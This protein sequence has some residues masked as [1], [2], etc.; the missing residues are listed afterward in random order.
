MQF[1]RLEITRNDAQFVL[2]CY[3]SRRKGAEDG[4]H[5]FHADDVE[6]GRAD[7]SMAEGDRIILEGS[8][9]DVDL[10]HN[11]HIDGGD[12]LVAEIDTDPGTDHPV[13]GIEQV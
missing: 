3:L 11:R 7:L 13:I 4:N 12:G 8:A 10:S 9:I 2:S 1:K 5:T 6:I